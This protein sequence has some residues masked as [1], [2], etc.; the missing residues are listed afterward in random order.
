MTQLLALWERLWRCRSCG[1]N[2]QGLWPICPYD[3]QPKDSL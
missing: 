2:H 3:N 1:G